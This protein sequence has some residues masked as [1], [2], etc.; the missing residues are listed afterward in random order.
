MFHVFLVEQHNVYIV[1][2]KEKSKR[3][4]LW[5]LKRNKLLPE[6]SFMKNT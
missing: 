6:N 2:T 1:N 4:G 3:D 5:C